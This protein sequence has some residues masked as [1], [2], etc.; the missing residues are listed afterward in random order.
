MV[1]DTGR[2]VP[3]I[4][5]G[6][7]PKVRVGDSGR[8]VAFVMDPATGQA[9]GCLRHAVWTSVGFGATFRDTKGAPFRVTT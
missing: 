2:R 4:S 8:A 5:M 9:R 1:K 3:F 6:A 7:K